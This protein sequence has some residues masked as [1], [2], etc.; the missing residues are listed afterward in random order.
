M[1]AATRPAAVS[2]HARKT[3]ARPT[4]VNSHSATSAGAIVRSGLAFG[5]APIKAGVAMYAITSHARVSRSLWR[6][7]NAPSSAR[8]HANGPTDAI[9]ADSACMPRAAHPAAGA[10]KRNEANSGA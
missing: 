5:H 10:G 2:R 9:R 3:S 1:K 8:L 6:S 7:E 4:A